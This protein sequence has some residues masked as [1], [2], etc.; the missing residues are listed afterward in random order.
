MA[1]CSISFVDGSA[2]DVEGD[3]EALIEELHKV[4]SRREHS[5]ALLRDARGATI[6][7]RPEAVVCVRAGS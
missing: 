1:V 4:A 6:A 7:V 2:V 5:F 3:L